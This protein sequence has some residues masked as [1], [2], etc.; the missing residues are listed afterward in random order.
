METSN[1]LFCLHS[2]ICTHYK[3][4]KV[5]GKHLK[6]RTNMLF[7]IASMRKLWR[8]HLKKKKLETLYTDKD[9]TGHLQDS[10]IPWSQLAKLRRYLADFPVFYLKV[11]LRANGMALWAEELRAK[12]EKLPSIPRILMMEGRNQISASFPT[13]AVTPVHTHIHIRGTHILSILVNGK[14]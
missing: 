1:C 9:L 5:T 13:D 12:S 7:P 4:P 8:L 6:T 3:Y 11:N 14:F 2:C 10:E